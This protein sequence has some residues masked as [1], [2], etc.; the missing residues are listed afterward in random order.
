MKQIPLGV[1]TVNHRLMTYGSLWGKLYLERE[2]N[3]INDSVNCL[4][5]Q[6]LNLSPSPERSVCTWVKFYRILTF[7]VVL[8]GMLHKQK[9]TTTIMPFC[10]CKKIATKTKVIITMLK[11]QKPNAPK[12][13][14]CG[15]I[16]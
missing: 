1:L 11:T 12:L 4:P 8:T 7:S 13:Y 10:D 3:S 15:P 5:R 2:R 9:D 14:R 16:N 6:R